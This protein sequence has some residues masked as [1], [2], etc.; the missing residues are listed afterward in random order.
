MLTPVSDERN[1]MRTT[2]TNRPSEGGP[3]TTEYFSSRVHII[4]QENC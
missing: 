1:P 4:C 2:K 3:Q